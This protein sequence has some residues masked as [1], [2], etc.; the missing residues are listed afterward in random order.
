MI[1][2]AALTTFLYLFKADSYSFEE[3]YRIVYEHTNDSSLAIYEQQNKENYLP[4]LYVYL[5][6]VE[7]RYSEI[8]LGPKISESEYGYILPY[9]L[10]NTANDV[11]IVKS[12]I[13]FR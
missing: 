10:N 13:E 11:D 2:E 8:M 9:I 12:N 7:T 3:E 1:L 5:T 6:Y 4:F